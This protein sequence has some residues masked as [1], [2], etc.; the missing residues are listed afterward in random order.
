MATVTTQLTGVEAEVLRADDGRFEAM[1]KGDWAGL[2]AALADDLI[3][4]HSTARQES[5]AEH[6]ANLRAGK[7]NYRGIAPR[8]CAESSFRITPKT[9][10][11]TRPHG[12]A[13][14]VLLAGS[15][16]DANGGIWTVF[17]PIGVS[18][19]TGGLASSGDPDPAP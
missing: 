10:G 3:Y 11:M 6:I 12:N 16:G 8:G 14:N 1:R 9:L 2:D 17:S 4:V 7:P 19:A 13:Q 18:T 15:A 5:K